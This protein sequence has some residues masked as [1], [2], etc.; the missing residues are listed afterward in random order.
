M[1]IGIAALVAAVAF[2]GDVRSQTPAQSKPTRP[3]FE[4]ASV[5]KR[6]GPGPASVVLGQDVARGRFDRTITAAGLIL[7]AYDLRDYQLIG[8]PDWMRTDRFDV[9]ATAGRDVPAA[10]L[11]LMVQSLLADRFRLT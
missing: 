3:V 2:T 4:V 7:Y 9:A 5:K 11:R 10:E 8:G 1:R 6:I